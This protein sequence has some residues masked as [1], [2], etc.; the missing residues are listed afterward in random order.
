MNFVSEKAME[1]FITISTIIAALQWNQKKWLLFCYNL[2][3]DFVCVLE[4]IC[5]EWDEHF[6]FSSQ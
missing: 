6:V 1:N 3:P 5:M 4:A 2:I